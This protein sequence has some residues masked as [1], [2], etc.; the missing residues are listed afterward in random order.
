MKTSKTNRAM[1]CLFGVVS[2]LTLSSCGDVGCVINFDYNSMVGNWVVYRHNDT[3]LETNQQTTVV[4]ALDSVQTRCGMDPQTGLW[5]ESKG[6]AISVTENIISIHGNGVSME[7]G[8]EYFGGNAI[9]YTVRQYTINGAPVSQDKMGK[10]FAY[11]SDSDYSKAILG[12][13]EGAKVGDSQ[14]AQRW[15]F[16]NDMTCK[17]YEGKDANG[18]WILK[19]S[20]VYYIYGDRVV[21]TY[22]KDGKQVSEAWTATI[23]NGQMKWE[24][25]RNGATEAYKFVNGK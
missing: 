15:C 1:A 5:T 24:A 12:Y 25:V 4:N 18:N 10:F 11:K 8:I 13:W 14:N 23:D 22:T 20:G 9:R 6:Y 19:S 16:M 17:I 3:V 21:C 7:L 2:L